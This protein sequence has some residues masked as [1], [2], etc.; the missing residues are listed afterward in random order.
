MDKQEHLTNFT[1][2]NPLLWYVWWLL[3]YRHASP[4][5]PVAVDRLT[6]YWSLSRFDVSL[7]NMTAMQDYYFY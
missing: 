7:S 6:G 3:T 1:I 2:I 5:R 4:L